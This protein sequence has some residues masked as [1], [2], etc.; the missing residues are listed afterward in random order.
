[1]KLGYSTGCHQM[2]ERSFHVNGR[3]FPVCARC[4]GV[5]IGN[6][7]AYAM[8]LIYSLPLRI[9]ILGCG[10]MFIDWLVQYHGIREST[11]IRRLI[12]GIVGGYS[13]T[14]LYC[15][16]IK[17]AVLLLFNRQIFNLSGDTDIFSY[18]F[19]IFLPHDSRPC[20]V[21]YRERG[22]F[23]TVCHEYCKR[24]YCGFLSAVLIMSSQESSY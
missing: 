3:P 18:S 20:L 11:N 7:A 6:I 13:L 2:P 22:T 15:M 19:K 5:L 8:F 21:A 9:C 16:A 24:L 17:Y 4:T 12:T 14:T 10:L 23:I 1:M